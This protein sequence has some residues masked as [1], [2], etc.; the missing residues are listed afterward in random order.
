M[1]RFFREVSLEE[2]IILRK[3]RAEK[4]AVQNDT[5]KILAH[6]LLCKLDEGDFTF[7]VAEKTTRGTMTTIRALFVAAAMMI[8]G[9]V[10]QAAPF[11]PSFHNVEAQTFFDNFSY[12]PN[13]G[14]GLQT[15]SLYRAGNKLMTA[16]S[17]DSTVK[18]PWYALGNISTAQFSQAFSNYASQ[19]F[20]PRQLAVLVDGAGQPKFTAIWKKLAGESFYTWVNMSDADFNAKWN[21]LVV[22]QHY[23]IED[24]A[25]YMVGGQK[26]HAAIYVRDGQPFYFFIGMNQSGFAQKFNQLAAQGFYPTS[27]NA[28]STPQGETYAGVWMKATGPTAM[29]FNMSAADYQAKFNQFS[30]QGLRVMK[31]Q[32]YANGTRFAAIWKK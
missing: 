30:A 2:K 14:L 31:I 11:Y 18:G 17:F 3:R 29:Y 5:V 22:N 7:E 8:S 1:R 25:A 16:G 32:G 21:D 19:G 6:R 9:M 23:R 20:R 13:Q 15:L 28:V 24:Y 12:Y 10:A 27:F 4:M 26:R